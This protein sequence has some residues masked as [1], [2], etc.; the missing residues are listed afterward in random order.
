MNATEVQDSYVGQ[1]QDHAEREAR[2]P[3]PWLRRDRAG[4]MDRFVVAGFPTRRME[5]WKYD[6][7]APVTEEPFILSEPSCIGL[8]PEDLDPLLLNRG[9]GAHLVFVNGWFAPT[10]SAG[11]ALPRGV[12]M[13][14]MARR[15]A[16][17]PAELLPAFSNEEAQPDHGFTEL[18]RAMWQD[19]AFVQL[20][21]ELDPEWTVQLLF[22]N[23]ESLEP[24]LIQP[25]NLLMVEAGCR[26]RVVETHLSLGRS[27]HFTNAWTT[28]LLERGAHL[29]YQLWLDGGPHA[30]HIGSMRVTQAA[31]SVLEAGLFALGGRLTR[32]EVEVNLSEP[33]AECRLHGLLAAT[34]HQQVDFHLNVRHAASSTTSHQ[35][36]RGLADGHGRGIFNGRVWVAP[37]VREIVSGQTTRNMLLSP[38]AEIDA[39][40]QLEIHADDVQCVHGAT[41]GSPDEEALFYLRSRGLDGQ[42]ALALLVEAFV[43]D[44]LNRGEPEPLRDWMKQR[45]NA[46][47]ASP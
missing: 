41:V 21:P 23:S 45:F 16:A 19:G 29:D 9:E 6:V 39:K 4:A 31:D 30:R 44:V 17:D 43:G 10:L 25:R 12:R 35:E 14:G 38:E 24:L 33:G 3:P 22:L 46:W 7:L 18:N 26:A 13:G 42:T 36:F 5:A 11:S 28:L 47:R 15:M 2:R 20:G 8:D 32:Q 27:A 37:G 34:A 40:P 1:F